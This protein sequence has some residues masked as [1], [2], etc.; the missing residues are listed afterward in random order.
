MPI[1]SDLRKACRGQYL[2]VFDDEEDAVF[3]N[4]L[5]NHWLNDAHRELAFTS[6]LYR[7][8]KILDVSLGAN[9]YSYA[10]LPQDVIEVIPDTVRWYNGGQW[11]ELEHQEEDHILTSGPTD[12]LTNG[13]PSYYFLR[14][15]AELGRQ[16]MIFLYPGATAAV[17]NGLR[18]GCWIYP[19]EMTDAT[20]ENSPAFQP[21]EH[22]WLV[23]QVTAKMAE[24]DANRGR[25]NAPVV[26]QE[27]KA[28]IAS[29]HLRQAQQQGRRP[30]GRVIQYVEEW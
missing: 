17:T 20:T 2:G 19:A 13:T 12:N 14:A 7:A 8:T 15:G 22:Q 1:L 26:L 18:I 10:G 3:T 25:D 16:R 6:K 30:G 24:L 4:A 9:G 5:L 23:R 28:E 21:A 11:L 29:D 27:R